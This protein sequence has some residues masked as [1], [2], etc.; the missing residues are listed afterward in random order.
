MYF[1][2][3][4][5]TIA[6]MNSF[7]SSGGASSTF[8][9]VMTEPKQS[10]KSNEDPFKNSIS[11]VR[12]SLTSNPR[13]SKAWRT[14]S[15][16]PSGAR[17]G[18]RTLGSAPSLN[19]LIDFPDRVFKKT[20]AATRSESSELKSSSRYEEHRPAGH[21]PLW[22]KQRESFLHTYAALS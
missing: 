10:E 14:N 1:G 9:F 11:P 8:G 21:L 13:R 3:L 2:D 16:T 7:S 5:T 22:L 18:S 12:S 4:I 20:T 19:S 15:I 17:Y 6:S